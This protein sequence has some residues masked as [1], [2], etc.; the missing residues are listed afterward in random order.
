M[1]L[2]VW[3]QVWGLISLLTRLQGGDPAGEDA[4]GRTLLRE[5]ICCIN[6]GLYHDEEVMIFLSARGGMK[7]LCT[8][9]EHA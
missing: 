8:R 4:E 6:P 9:S 2:P 7:G 1:M 5:L 3:L